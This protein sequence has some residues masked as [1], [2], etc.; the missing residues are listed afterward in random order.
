MRIKDIFLSFIHLSLHM[1]RS[2]EVF[3][4]TSFYEKRLPTFYGLIPNEI[5]IFL[6]LTIFLIGK[7]NFESFTPRAA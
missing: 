6:I 4:P 2:E 3:I 5:E 7:N 1:L